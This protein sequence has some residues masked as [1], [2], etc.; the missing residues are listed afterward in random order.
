MIALPTTYGIFRSSRVCSMV[1]AT[2]VCGCSFDISTAIVVGEG[3][4]LQYRETSR[5]V[6]RKLAGHY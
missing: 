6:A 5:E 4:K 1:K 3:G 2:E